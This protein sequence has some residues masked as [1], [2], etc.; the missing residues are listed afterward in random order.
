[1][2]TRR[3]LSKIKPKSTKLSQDQVLEIRDMLAMGYKQT[4]LAKMY[5][6]TSQAIYHIS[7]GDSWGWLTGLKREKY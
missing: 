4:E 2:R 7:K 3:Q 5:G 6:V 1:M